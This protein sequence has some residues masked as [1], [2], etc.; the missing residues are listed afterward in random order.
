MNIKLEL[1]SA[2][3]YDIIKRRLDYAI[4]MDAD[5]IA[6]TKAISMLSEIQKIIQNKDMSD[7]DMVEAIV[8]LFENNFISAG[9]CH[10]FV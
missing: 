5:Q 3:I 4:E 9:D 6:D 7:F 2:T 10:D 1:L 8:V